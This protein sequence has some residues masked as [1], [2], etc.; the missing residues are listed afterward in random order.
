M[1]K[2]KDDYTEK[3]ASSNSQIMRFY[4]ILNYIEQIGDQYKIENEALENRTFWQKVIDKIKNKKGTDY[5][6]YI[7][8]AASYIQD[9][10]KGIVY[11]VNFLY[12][13]AEWI[14]Y[15]KDEK[16]LQM[17]GFFTIDIDETE[18]KKMSMKIEMV[19]GLTKGDNIVEII[20]IVDTITVNATHNGTTLS[21]T[22]ALEMNKEQIEMIELVRYIIKL[23]VRSYLSD[24]IR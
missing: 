7:G 21:S 19:D 4:G 9:L 6:Y 20:V 12:A 23:M 8:N 14:I 15:C 11:D 17:S 5:S 18:K 10:F 22:T 2:Y 1:T 24:K 16:R 13:L 3:M